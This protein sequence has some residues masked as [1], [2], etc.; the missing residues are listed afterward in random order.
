MESTLDAELSWKEFI[1]LRANDST[2][3]PERYIRI[4][5]DLKY[6]PPKLDAKDQLHAL[7]KSTRKALKRSTRARAEIARVG[8]TMVPSSLYY[9]S[10]SRPEADIRDT[11]C[12]TGESTLL[13]NLSLL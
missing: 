13:S 4:N 8:R 10:A 2:A 11:Y 3:K 6:Q 12:C 5:P 7:H 1:S 9:T